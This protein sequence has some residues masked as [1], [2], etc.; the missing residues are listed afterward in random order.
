MMS[1]NDMEDFNEHPQR[2][3]YDGKRMRTKLI[4]RRV[5]DYNSGVVSYV[6]DRVYARDHRD[7]PSVQ[8]IAAAQERYMCPLGYL[9][10][11]ATSITSK[12]VHT[13][14]NKIKC[15]VN[16]VVWTPEGRRLIAGS[17]TGEFTLWNGLAFNF[18]TILQAHTGAVRAMEWS[19]NGDWMVSG[20]HGGEI[21][22]W[23]P[24]MANMQKFRGHNEAIRDISFCRTDHKFATC[25]DDCTI[26]IWDFALCKEENALTGHGWDVRCL[27]WHP[28]NSLIVS[29]SKDNDIKIWDAKSGQRIAT[30]HGHK[31]AVL[32]VEWNKNG[33]WLLTA[34]RDQQIKLY[35]IR[36]MREIQNFKG[37][38][39]EVCSLAWHPIHE[40]FFVSGG[41]DGVLNFWNC[42]DSLSMYEVVGA[43]ENSVWSLA[44]HPNG[45]ILA[46]GS[47][48]YC[49]KFWS[50]QSPG[51]K[52]EKKYHVQAAYHNHYD[53]E[54]EENQ[55]ALRQPDLKQSLKL[56]ANPIVTP[57]FVG[58]KKKCFDIPWLGKK[59]KPSTPQ[60]LQE[61]SSTIHIKNEP[62]SL[63][64]NEETMN[65][66]EVKKEPQD[67]LEGMQPQYLEQMQPQD[68]EQIQPEMEQEQQPQFIEHEES[69]SYNN[70]NNN[71]NNNNIEQIQQHELEHEHPEENEIEEEQEMRVD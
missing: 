3:T 41:N 48:D 23:M 17:A 44:W 54:L 15:P 13:S 4:N 63:Q 59:S 8:P 66:V 65:L 52:M 46:S 42:D 10:N 39:R 29:G 47:N 56:A 38:K 45:H 21:M 7:W 51:D 20:D 61:Q 58:D 5:T 64:M 26:K 70:N 30:L 14:T 60:L 43:H 68:L 33:N 24:N 9:S 40:D 1:L 22:Y 34:S 62:G 11:P 16:C 55:Q 32:D 18:E 69:H 12:F 53:P 28:Q 37:H 35:D 50:R 31:N 71:N 2:M 6:K 67:F 57:G 49:T 36:T 25:S 27:A 19:H